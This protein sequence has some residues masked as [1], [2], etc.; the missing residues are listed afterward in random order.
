MKHFTLLVVALT[1]MC[2]TAFAQPKPLKFIYAHNS[3]LNVQQ[4]QSENPT[5]LNRILFAGYNTL[6]LPMT[7]T[8]EQLQQA[9]PD[10]QVER[11]AAIRQ[12]GN[13]VNLYFLDC[14]A[15]GIQP[16]TLSDEQGNRVT[17]ASSWSQ[18]NGD[19]RFGIPAKQDTEILQ[20]VLVRTQPDQHFLPTRC[21]FIWEQ[22]STTATE[23]QIKHVASLDCIQTSVQTLK[24][25]NALVDVYDT[26]G[27][28]IRR[29]V[30][31][32]S[33]TDNLP[34]GI[35]VVGGEKVLVR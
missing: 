14:T 4:L 34:A 15:E 25:K 24:A 31:I 22:Q 13:T 26:K 35:Y 21:G 2:S 7:L 32:N 33:A 19:G 18:L 3:A 27:T 28:L 5:Q 9:A 29:Q 8:A 16:V 6:C 23:L 10:V 30:S 17:F 1:T 12:E 20:S 11:L